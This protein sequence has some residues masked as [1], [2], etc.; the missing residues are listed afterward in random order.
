MIFPLIFRNY[1]YNTDFIILIYVA[2][3]Y[4]IY[5]MKKLDHEIYT[6]KPDFN[7]VRIKIPF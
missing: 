7:N 2:D 5:T 3:F 6:M 1:F 4:N